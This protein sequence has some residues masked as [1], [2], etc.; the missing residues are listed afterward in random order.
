MY[1]LKERIR[2]L[3]SEYRYN[4]TLSVAEEC[5]TLAE[6]FGIDGKNLIISGYL[7]DI[8]KE[9]PTKDQIELCEKMGERLEGYELLSEKTLHSYSAPALIKRDF[10][11]YATDEILS[12]VRYHTT[13]RE[14][15]TLTEKLLYL[16]DYIEKTRKF[17]ECKRL[18]RFFYADL[19]DPVKRLD[20]T[21]LL[22]LKYTLNELLSKDNFIHP[23]TLN[24][25]N[26]LLIN[27]K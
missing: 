27:Q 3:M 21:V 7:H 25:Y 9:L 14:N 26:S 20:E 2:P 16:A 17:D 22:S 19:S 18:R 1:E 13:G 6:I 24:A 5:K 23:Q 12:A 11:E 4:H 15:M 8:T 10:P